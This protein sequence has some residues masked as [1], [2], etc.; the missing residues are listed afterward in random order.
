MIVVDVRGVFGLGGDAKTEDFL[1]IAYGAVCVEQND[2]P[3]HCWITNGKKHWIKGLFGKR[4]PQ[5]AAKYLQER[6]HFI[7]FVYERKYDLGE[8]PRVTSWAANPLLF[9][10]DQESARRTHCLYPLVIKKA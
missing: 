1:E 2:C 6:I 10:S 5:R 7:H 8:I 9:N 4:N 3:S